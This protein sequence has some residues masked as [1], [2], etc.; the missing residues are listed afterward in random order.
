[1]T[2]ND[3]RKGRWSSQGRVY[4]LTF[5][6]HARSPLFEDFKLGRI[7]V[8]E[9]RALHEQGMV[10]S[11]AFVVMPDHAHWLV[12][13]DQGKLASITQILKGR[14]ARCINIK[15][16]TT[17][18]VWQPG[19]YD[20]TLRSDEDLRNQARYIVA[21]PLRAGLVSS[22]SDYPLWDAAWLEID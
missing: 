1:M 12:T 5:V 8:S 21:N 9:M 6:T 18:P 4:A 16:Q 15:R 7:V 11:L 10:D 13:L 3:L 2:Y 22:V 20:H 14:S 17:G 19:Y